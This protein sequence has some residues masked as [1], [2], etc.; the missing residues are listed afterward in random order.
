MNMIIC[1]SSK[2]IT[3]EWGEEYQRDDGVSQIVVSLK[4]G[5]VVSAAWSL[6]IRLKLHEVSMPIS[7]ISFDQ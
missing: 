6:G 1:D 5:H 4:L 7:I 3:R 2:C